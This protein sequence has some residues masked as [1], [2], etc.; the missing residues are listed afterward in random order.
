MSQQNQPSK[1]LPQQVQNATARLEAER[2]RSKITKG[3]IQV[4]TRGKQVPFSVGIA[5][6]RINLNPDRFW[7][8]TLPE[9]DGNGHLSD[10]WCF[11]VIG[12]G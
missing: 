5:S 10:S 7:A 2:V 1:Q 11:Y 6:Q 9:K 3:M 12:Y 4:F 8:G